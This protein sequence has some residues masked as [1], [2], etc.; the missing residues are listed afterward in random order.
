MYRQVAVFYK[1]VYGQM[2]TEEMF[3][4]TFLKQSNIAKN[5]YIPTSAYKN[6]VKNQYITMYK[7]QRINKKG[8]PT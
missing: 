2:Y 8:E 5:T 4:N 1:S 6:K 7:R 3:V